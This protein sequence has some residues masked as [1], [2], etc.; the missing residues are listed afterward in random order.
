[1]VLSWSFLELEV[2]HSAA[3]CHKPSSKRPFE[4]CGCFL[5]DLKVTVHG[6]IN[7]QR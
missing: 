7:V 3:H 5:N 2:E 4:A 6:A 1:M